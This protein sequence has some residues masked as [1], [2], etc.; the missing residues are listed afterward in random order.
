MSSRIE[1]KHGTKPRMALTV[2]SCG[3]CHCRRSWR[4][5]GGYTVNDPTINNVEH[6]SDEQLLLLA[7][8]AGVRHHVTTKKHVNGIL[9]PS[10]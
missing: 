6:Y 5:G 7:D 2:Q 9:K 4:C 8:G 1:D 10:F 3:S